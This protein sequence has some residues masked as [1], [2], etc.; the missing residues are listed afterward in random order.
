MIWPAVSPRLLGG[1]ILIVVLVGGGFYLHHKGYEAGEASVQV[2]W[3]AEKLIVEKEILEA[4]L[5]NKGKQLAD[6]QAAEVVRNELQE[7][8][9]DYDNR[10][11]T[12][13]RR[14]RDYQAHASGCA[15]PGDAGAPGGT[16]ET[17]GELPGAGEVEQAVDDVRK[18]C[19][20]D[21]ARLEGW[22]AWW[23]RISSTS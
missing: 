7:K 2:R 10:Y 4:E 3:D 12:L 9:A 19:I 20:N 23:K 16:P 22:Q 11:S 8:I 13:A 14:L 17:G 18:A 1:G 6:L 5:R 21:A 15:L